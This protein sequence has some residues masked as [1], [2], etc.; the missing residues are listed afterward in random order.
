MDLC[1]Y[2]AAQ[3]IRALGCDSFIVG[4]NGNL[5]PDDISFFK[6]S[7]ANNVLLNPLKMR[8]LEDAWEENRVVSTI[9]ERRNL[10]VTDDNE[11]DL[12]HGLNAV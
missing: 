7:G 10:L 8:D 6:A 4:I 11:I 5:F 2:G 9:H 1:T 12:E 3:K